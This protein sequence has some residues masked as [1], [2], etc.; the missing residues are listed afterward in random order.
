MCLPPPSWVRQRNPAVR[1]RRGLLSGWNLNEWAL[2]A[3]D[4]SHQ[5]SHSGA[6]VYED[7]IFSILVNG[8][9]GNFKIAPQSANENSDWSAV[10]G[11]TVSDGN[12][13]LKAF[14]WQMLVQ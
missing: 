3:L 11:N 14:Y 13:A 4:E 2:G 9:E 8:M 6:D 7:P 5:F 10:F 12:T 1:N